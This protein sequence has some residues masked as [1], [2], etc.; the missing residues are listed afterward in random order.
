MQL[1]VISKV[2]VFAETFGVRS[3]GR[4]LISDQLQRIIFLMK[5]GYPEIGLW[6]HKYTS[7]TEHFPSRGHRHIITNHEVTCS[8][9]YNW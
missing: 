8:C 6:L 1:R 9:R 3:V 2:S 7:N 5:I 4:D